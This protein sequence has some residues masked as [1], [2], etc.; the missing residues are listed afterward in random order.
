MLKAISK[1]VA[2]I[3]DGQVPSNEATLSL[4][5][6][7]LNTAC[8]TDDMRV[9]YDFVL[10]FVIEERVKNMNARCIQR[11]FKRAIADPAYPLCVNRLMR[12]YNDLVCL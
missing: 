6:A 12:E 5:K 2:E 3:L 10:G 11:R 4:L 8:E 1:W 7:M 9:A